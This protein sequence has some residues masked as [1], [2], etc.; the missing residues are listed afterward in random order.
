MNILLKDIPRQGSNPGRL[1]PF[2]SEPTTA[3]FFHLVSFF[4]SKIK[5]ANAMIF[6]HLDKWNSANVN[7]TRGR[8]LN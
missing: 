8:F 7:K 4:R 2:G 5:M 6:V 1:E 3:P